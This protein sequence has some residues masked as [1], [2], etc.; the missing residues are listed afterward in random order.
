MSCGNVSYTASTLLIAADPS[1]PNDNTC[2]R[3]QLSLDSAMDSIVESRVSDNPSNVTRY[4]DEKR[5][6]LISDSFIVIKASTATTKPPPAS[7]QN[8]TAA[9][10]DATQTE[11]DTEQLDRGAHL[12]GRGCQRLSALD[13]YNVVRNGARKYLSRAQ[14]QFSDTW[15]QT[16]G[17]H[18][19]NTPDV[20]AQEACITEGIDRKIWGIVDPPT[21]KCIYSRS[22]AIHI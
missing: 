20:V 1:T 14:Q 17:F 2:T 15:L 3:V 16:R 12:H 9:G 7:T 4:A 5:Q 22:L 8:A 10:N 18:A 19:M 21:A 6:A 13:A 11:H